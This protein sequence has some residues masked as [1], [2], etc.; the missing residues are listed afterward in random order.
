MPRQSIGPRLVRRRGKPNYYIRYIDSANG[1]QKDVS[2]N[3]RDSEEAQE[4][5]EE[6]LR[7][8]LLD[9]A[10]PRILEGCVP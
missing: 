9:A 10:H 8:R 2:T 4:I 7:D 5:L 3:T 1:Q 6:F